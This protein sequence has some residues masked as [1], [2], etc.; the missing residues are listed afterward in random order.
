MNLLSAIAPTSIP[1]DPVEG[2][3]GR[4][5]FQAAVKAVQAAAAA[6]AEI[7]RLLDPKV[8]QFIDRSA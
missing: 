8:G 7:V 5:G 3:A 1:T 4:V 6:Q 2:I